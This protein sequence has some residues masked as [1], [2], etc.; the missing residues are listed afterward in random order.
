[1]S[2]QINHDAYNTPFDWKGLGDAIFAAGAD[3]KPP[4]STIRL[5]YRVPGKEVR[6]LLGREAHRQ[7]RAV[8]KQQ[9]LAGQAVADDELRPWHQLSDA[10]QEVFR[11]GGES[12][13]MPEEAFWAELERQRKLMGE[14]AFRKKIFELSVAAVIKKEN[15]NWTEAER[16]QVSDIIEKLSEMFDVPAPLARV[17]KQ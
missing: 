5:T 1:L 15:P 7:W 17:S 6:E 2:A 4:P 11:K 10:E 14:K 13:A 8:R 3:L 12:L 16:Y 9:Q